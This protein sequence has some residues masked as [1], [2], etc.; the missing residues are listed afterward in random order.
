MKVLVLSILMFLIVEK[1]ICKYNA[2]CSKKIINKLRRSQNV[3]N[4]HFNFN[5]GCKSSAHDKATCIANCGL[6]SAGAT[7]TTGCATA[8]TADK[9][10]ECSDKCAAKLKE[11]TDKCTNG[12]ANTFEGNLIFTT[13]TFLI[14][15]L[16]R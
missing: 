16:I 3:P 7:C 1:G 5:I 2:L 4:F 9:I 6:S 14:Y 8:G 10:K 13:A 12:G 11:C 15:Q